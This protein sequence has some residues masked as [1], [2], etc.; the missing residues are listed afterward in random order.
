LALDWSYGGWGVTLAQNW[1]G[2]YNDIPASF[3]DGTDPAF[4]PRKVGA[5]E[6]YDLQTTY[7]GIK[8]L[9]FTLGARNILNRDPPY[10]NTGGQVT[11][12]SG[13]DPEY[14]DPRGRFVY[15]RIT[16]SMK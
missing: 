10:T 3:E 2:R 6:T 9:R 1:Q 5:Y 15:G 12:Q 16:Y 4:V 8:S 13:Y 11:F 7:S 14:A